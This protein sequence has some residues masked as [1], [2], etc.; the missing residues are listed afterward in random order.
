MEV[1]TVKR[2]YSGHDGI[3]RHNG[4]KIRGLYAVRVQVSLA[5][6]IYRSKYDETKF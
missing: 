3:G 1:S 6:P 4:L 2:N 5:A